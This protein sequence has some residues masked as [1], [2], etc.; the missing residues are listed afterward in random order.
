MLTRFNPGQGYPVGSKLY[1]RCKTCGET[2]PSQSPDS[3]GCKCGNI[4]IDVDYAR[5][6]V[7]RDGDIELLHYMRSGGHSM[8]INH[9]MLRQLFFPKIRF[10]LKALIRSVAEP[11]V[12]LRGNIAQHEFSKIGGVTCVSISI[13]NVGQRS[14]EDAYF[15]VECKDCELIRYNPGTILS[16]NEK[17]EKSAGAYKEFLHPHL[18]DTFTFAVVSTNVGHGNDTSWTIKAYARDMVPLTCSIDSY[19]HRDP[20]KSVDFI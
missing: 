2:I 7:K 17:R 16:D 9:E 3:H 10:E 13:K 6:S 19:W 12:M 8:E 18:E 20:E 11:V 15:F 1:Y 14:L 4:F 5:V